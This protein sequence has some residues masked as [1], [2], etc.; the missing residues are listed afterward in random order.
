MTA[1]SPHPPP[2]WADRPTAARHAGVSERTI[3]RWRQDGRIIAYR[4]GAR[5]I[6]YD[7][8]EIDAMAEVAR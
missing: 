5:A 8:N 4:F 1:T 3:D 7:L 2:R 6:R